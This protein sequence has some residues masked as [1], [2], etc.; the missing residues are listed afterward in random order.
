MCEYRQVDVSGDEMGIAVATRLSDE[1]RKCQTLDTQR[2]HRIFLEHYQTS[3]S[4]LISHPGVRHLPQINHSSSQKSLKCITILNFLPNQHAYST[5][6]N[7]IPFHLIPPPRLLVPSYPLLTFLTTV[8]VVFATFFFF[9]RIAQH[10]INNERKRIP[11]RTQRAKK[12]VFTLPSR[13]VKEQ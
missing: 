12:A 8:I 9:P 11:T 1:H 13:A 4:L 3:N 6:P 2:A 10:E 5:P 7:H